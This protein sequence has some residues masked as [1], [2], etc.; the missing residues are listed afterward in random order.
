MRGHSV[1]RIND[2]C[3]VAILTG[4]PKMA[5]IRSYGDIIRYIVNITSPCNLSVSN[6]TPGSSREWRQQSSWYAS[7]EGRGDRNKTELG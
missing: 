4:L 6:I 5:M 1:A 2:G 3:F 7:Q